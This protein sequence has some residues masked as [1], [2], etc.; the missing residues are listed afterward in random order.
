ML[1]QLPPPPLLLRHSRT[2][3]KRKDLAGHHKRD[4]FC[5]T[6]C[7]ENRCQSVEVLSGKSLE[8]R[9]GSD[10]RPGDQNYPSFPVNDS[11]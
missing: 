4:A 3:K 8:C 11:L 9:E 2:K 10:L 5:S 1:R 7:P 6:S